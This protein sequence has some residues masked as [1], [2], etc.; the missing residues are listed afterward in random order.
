MM[1][2]VTARRS[3][4]CRARAAAATASTTGTHTNIIS[5]AAPTPCS[6]GWDCRVGSYG[7]CV[8]SKA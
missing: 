7:C 1:M 6:E 8:S 5:R 3:M 2:R 4:I